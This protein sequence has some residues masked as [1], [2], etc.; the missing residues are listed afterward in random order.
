[1]ELK[2]I[3]RLVSSKRVYVIVLYITDIVIESL[4]SGAFLNALH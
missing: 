1:M 4:E 3:K 2:L